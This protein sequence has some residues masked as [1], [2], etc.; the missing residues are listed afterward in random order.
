MTLSFVTHGIILGTEHYDECL[1]FYRDT[2]GLPVW[3]DK[4][5]LCCLHLG[6]G[7]LMIEHGGHAKRAGRKATSENPI[8]LRFNVEDVRVAAD[9]LRAKGLQVDVRTF[10]W[11]TVGTFCDPDGNVCELKNSD[12]PYFAVSE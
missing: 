9:G 10:D 8:I 12:D 6:N 11:G 4:G 2:L 1:E 3:Y 5:H 7:Y